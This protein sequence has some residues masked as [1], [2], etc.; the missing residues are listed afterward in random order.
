MLL[1]KLTR[2]KKGVSNIISILLITSIMITSVSLTYV[3]II[4]TI[5]RGRM[6]SDVSTAALF[7]TKMDAAIQSMFF[8]GVGSTRTLEMDAFPGNL[9][10]VSGGMNFRAFLDGVMYLPIPGLDYGIARIIL[11]NDVPIIQRNSYK[12]LKGS[13]YYPPAITEE[14]ELDP[15]VIVLERPLAETYYISLYYR[16]F[17]LIRD[18]GVGST[19]DVNVIVARF[20][21]SESMRGL[22]SGNYHLIIN[23]TSSELNPAIHGFT[24]NDPIVSS[25]NDFTITLNPGTGPVTIYSS[26]GFRSSVSI[27]LVLMTFFFQAVGL[28]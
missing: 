1:K 25:G 7:L 21:A 22:T 3:Y 15:A 4:P 18:Q 14:G 24:D 28:E 26:T 19:I 8:D 10:Y 13:P 12:F 17:I 9:E 20:S 27:N 11:E 5:D 23:K 2:N 16:L 6:N